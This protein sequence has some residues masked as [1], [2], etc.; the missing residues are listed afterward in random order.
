MTIKEIEEA[1]GMQRANIRYYETEGFINPEREKNGYRNYSEAD[2]D[3][4][5]KIKLLRSLHISLE[6]I[7]AMHQGEQDFAKV[8]DVHIIHLTK[9][10]EELGKS[11]YV[12]EKMKQDGATYEKLNTEQY[13]LVLKNCRPEITEREEWV[14]RDVP[15]PLKAPYL[16]IFARLFDYLLYMFLWWLLVFACNTAFGFEETTLLV[17]TLVGFA[18]WMPFGLLLEPMFLCLF[19]ATPGKL[20]L[21]LYV[22]YD[23]AEYMPME[24]ARRRTWRA[25]GMLHEWEYEDIYQFT[26]IFECLEKGK[27]LDWDYE[28]NTTIG[29]KDECRWRDV[30]WLILTVVLVVGNVTLLKMLIGL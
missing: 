8:L 16:R 14:E 6:E 28:A 12:C 25:V 21:G 17:V 19:G 5:K 2:L 10:Q 24:V 27:T 26:R 4:L 7:K 15:K 11:K 22:T 9:Q 3:L 29:L 20:I 13:L 18:M 30:V 23:L 1:S